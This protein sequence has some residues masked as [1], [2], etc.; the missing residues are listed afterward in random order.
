MQTTEYNEATFPSS[1]HRDSPPS[2]P[3][4]GAHA[5]ASSPSPPY[6]QQH[7]SFPLLSCAPFLLPPLCVS[8]LISQDA[9]HPIPSGLV[10]AACLTLDLNVDP[11]LKIIERWRGLQ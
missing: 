2:L 10:E 5:Q 11:L 7:A 4:L 8:S 6:T 3:S 1:R 9:P